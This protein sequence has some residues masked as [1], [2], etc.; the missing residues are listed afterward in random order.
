MTELDQKAAREVVDLVPL[1]MRT[2]AAALRQADP[3]LAP[4]HLRLLGMLAARPCSLSELAE[5]HGV[6]RPTAS[7][8]VSALVARGWVQRRR[9]PADRR[10]VR[11]ELTPEGRR[12]L[13]RTRVQVEA[14]VAERLA[15]LPVEDQARLL[16]GLR[17]LRAAFTPEETGGPQ[18][19][20]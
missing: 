20:Q 18:D 10:R 8:S 6:S 19:G 7:N 5:R 4:P 15:A 14:Y 1:V 2:L 16:E 9:D 11:L 13:Q 12:V 3:G 17:L